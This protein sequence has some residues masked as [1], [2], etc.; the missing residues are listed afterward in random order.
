MRERITGLILAGG[1]GSRM[2]GRDKGL[3]MIGGQTLVAHAVQRLRPQVDELLVNANRNDAHYAAFGYPVVRD[4]HPGFP[5]PLA[6]IATGLAHTASGLLAVVPCDSPFLPRDLV[7][8]LYAALVAEHADVAVVRAGG[9]LQPVFALIKTQLHESL[10]RF[11][12]GSDSRI[13]GW[14]RLQKLAIVDFDEEA[15]FANL[16]AEDDC[17][18]AAARLNTERLSDVIGLAGY[19][20]SGKTTLLRKLLPLL[21]KEGLRVGV[22]KHAHHQFDLDQPGKDSYEIRHAGAARVLVASSQRWA[23]I[24]ERAE[25]GD[26]PLFGLVETMRSRELDL[27]LVEGF[28]HERFTKIEVHRPELDRPLLSAQDDSI[29]AVASSGPVELPAGLPAFALDDAAGIAQFILQLRGRTAA[30]PAAVP[31]DTA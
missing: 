18:Q 5:G 28:R 7:A 26:P 10:M 31:G 6:G 4:L 2:G 13:A 9:E 20:G 3:V 8:R 17:A 12:V 23:L 24:H 1:R 30:S 21:T 25:S 16:N 27:I 19:S 15:A 22:I 11:M 14:F 29:V